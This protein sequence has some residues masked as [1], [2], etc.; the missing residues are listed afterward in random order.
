M[1]TRGGTVLN[2]QATQENLKALR[3]NTMKELKS[4][5]ARNEDFF[6]MGVNSPPGRDRAAKYATA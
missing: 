2:T 6:V 5:Q 3:F 4:D 1:Q